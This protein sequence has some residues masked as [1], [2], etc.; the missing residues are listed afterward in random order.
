MQE[1]KIEIKKEH[2]KEAENIAT[3][4]LDLMSVK[5]DVKVTHDTENEALVVNIN[6]ENETGLLIGTRGETL[7]AIQSVLGLMMK[8]KFSGWIRV[9]VNIGDWRE[10]Q[11]DY[12]K[13]LAMQATERAIET[14]EPQMLYNLTPSQRRVIHMH[15][16]NEKKVQTE[17]V[18]ED[19]L[20]YL[21]IKPAR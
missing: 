16:A 15:L 7:L 17:S 19:E 21:I 11:E 10:K 6:S 4:L 3:K 12:L 14:G 9:V 2:I 20:R 18:G 13:S 1:D 5:A 8:Q